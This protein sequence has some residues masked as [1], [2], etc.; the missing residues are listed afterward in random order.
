MDLA[1]DNLPSNQTKKKPQTFDNDGFG[2]NAKVD[3]PRNQI[4]ALT[5]AG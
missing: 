4:K 3:I 1:V 2:I 5:L